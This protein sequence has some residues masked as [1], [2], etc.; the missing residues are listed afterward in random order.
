VDDH[1]RAGDR[2]D[3]AVAAEEVA[4]HPSDVGRRTGRAGLAAEH[5]DLVAG[6]Q[7]PA[8]HAAAEDAATAGD[9]NR[10]AHGQDLAVRKLD[11]T[12]FGSMW[13]T[14]IGGRLRPRTLASRP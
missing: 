4:G 1:P 7:Q 14:E 11:K 6:G 5:P 9:Q 3:E 8:D 13:R 2:L 12:G 10:L